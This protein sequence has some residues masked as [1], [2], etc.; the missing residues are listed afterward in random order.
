MAVLAAG[1][2]A[3]T[4]GGCATWQAPEAVEEDPA[5][6]ARAVTEAVGDV[7]LS[8]AVLSAEES[9]RIFGKD[10]NSAG[11]QP[12]WL[13]VE[14][15]TTDTLWLLRAGTDPDYFSPLEVA[16]SFHAALSSEKNAAIDEHFDALDF[17][18]PIPPYSR[19]G[20]IIFTNPHHRTRVVN[21]DLLGPGKVVPF[22]LFLP[23]PD[24]P[25]DETALEVIQHYA[26]EPREDFDDLDALRDALERL[27]CCASGTDGA[28]VGDP[29][30]LVLVGHVADIAAAL[31]RRGFRID[32]KDYDDVQQ[33]FGRRADFVARKAGQEVPAYWL[34]G[35]VTP[36][37]YKGQLVFLMQVGR[38]VGGRFAVADAAQLELHPYVDEAR[39]LLIQDLVY[40]GGLAR[41]GFAEGSGTGDER[42]QDDRDPGQSGY[43]SDGL[44]AVMFFVTRPVALSGVQTLNWVPYLERAER[45]TAARPS[46]AAP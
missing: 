6:R 38:P 39:N 17:P 42:S 29:L 4:I 12:L 1:V 16:W 13:E 14:N 41:L 30:N 7:R 20:G 46:N 43:F 5:I 27:P 8:A 22:T 19:V 10:V 44:R 32:R 21:V 26:K 34:R 11:I 9:R 40:S 33:V 24:N 25:P 15:A 31:V 2:L 23:V 36:L 28:G 18:N 45:E 3:A 35:W 37:R